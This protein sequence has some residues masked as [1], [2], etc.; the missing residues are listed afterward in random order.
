VATP[1]ISQRVKELPTTSMGT[2][3]KK[4]S[5]ISAATRESMNAINAI[6]SAAI[7]NDVLRVADMNMEKTGISGLYPYC[8]FILIG[9]R[10]PTLDLADLS[11]K[12]FHFWFTTLVKNSKQGKLRQGPMDDPC[13]SLLKFHAP[14]ATYKVASRSKDRLI[15]PHDG[16]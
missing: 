16:H 13:Y 10:D 12:R 4:P 14:F 5:G 8:F 6:I 7:S 15:W 3:Y 9:V 11:L 2:I 1:Q